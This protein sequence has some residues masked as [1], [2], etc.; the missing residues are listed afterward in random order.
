MNISKGVYKL[1][2]DVKV[3]QLM[4]DL[5]YKLL[6]SDPDKRIS[7]ENFFKHPVASSEPQKYK[8]FLDFLVAK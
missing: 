1:P 7:W 2:P 4:M 6:I 3:S 5:I 8:E